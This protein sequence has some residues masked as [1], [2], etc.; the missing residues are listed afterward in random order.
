MM[1]GRTLPAALVATAS[2]VAPC[3]SARACHL[4]DRCCG[5]GVTA[6]YAPVA[7][8][9]PACC[10][11]PQV[12]NYMPQ[13]CYRTVYVNTPVV[14]YQPMTACD[15]CGR[16]TTVMRP[17]TTFV[18]RPQLVPYTTYRPVAMSV[19][20]P[21]CGAP[22]VTTAAYAA[23]AISV[24]PAPAPAA[25]A[26]CAP[27]TAAA[28]YPAPAAATYAAPATTYAAAPAAAPAPA[29]APLQSVPSTPTPSLNGAPA[30]TPAQPPT[31]QSSPLDAN[32][33]QSRL[34]LPPS[35][36]SSSTRLQGGLDPEEQD[37]TT[38]IPLRGPIVRHAS[39][40]VP[41]TDKAADDGGRAGK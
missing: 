8:V 29:S 19:A 17:V 41:K 13:T 1:F 5:R 15:P 24:A 31:F 23:P 30:T 37:R 28:T 39:L 21:C 33:P 20:Q 40:V 18:A 6:Y 25:P 9:A 3:A 11:Q 22:A 32:Q 2:L 34:L 10:P 26:C 35:G 4:F 36:A 38:A 12:V 16:A 7:T 14:A 27:A